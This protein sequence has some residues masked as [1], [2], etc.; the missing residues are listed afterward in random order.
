MFLLRRLAF[1]AIAVWVAASVTFLL[2]HLAPGGPVVALGGEHGAP[3]QLEEVTRSYGLDRPLPVI[4]LDYISRLARG[5]LGFSYR[6]QLPVASLILERMPVTLGIMIPAILLAGCGGVVLGMASLPTTTRPRRLIGAG[7]AGLHALPSFVAAGVLVLV[8]SLWLGV[9]P[10]QGISDPRGAPMTP[11]QEMIAWLRHLAL[12]VAALALHQIT[13]MAL[14]TRV[15]V[16]EEMTRPYAVAV[17]AKG[18]SLRRTRWRHALPNAL[19]PI[20]TLLGARLGAFVGGTMVIETIFA[21]PGIGRLAVT[22]AIARDHP[23]V[24]GIVVVACAA[25]ILVNAIVDVLA[26]RLDPRIGA[27]RA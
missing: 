25:V 4:Y 24:I 21:L 22:S 6:A 8:F 9:L 26:M 15:R 16:A 12:P 11:G 1:A 19:L 2:A 13:F 5:D 17:R 10:V 14:L 23:T 20:L 7:L 3:G 18:A 27:A